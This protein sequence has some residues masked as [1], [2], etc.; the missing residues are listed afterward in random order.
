MCTILLPVG[1]NPIAVNKYI[2]SMHHLPYS[3]CTHCMRFQYPTWS[4]LFASP[5]YVSA[6]LT[7]L[8]K[9]F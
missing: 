9:E 3:Y 4:E 8:P 7:T 6:S 2:N 1:V 5:I